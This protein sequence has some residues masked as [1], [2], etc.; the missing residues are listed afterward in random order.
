M[1]RG[2]GVAALLAW[3]L[4]AAGGAALTGGHEGPATGERPTWLAALE[5][6]P[7][8]AA[9]R[10]VP[11]QDSTSAT[12]QARSIPATPATV[13]FPEPARWD[14]TL[15]R[16]T[17][18]DRRPVRL[19]ARDTRAAAAQVRLAVLDRAAAK[20]VGASGFVFTADIE[21]PTPVTLTVDYSGFAE[22]YGASYADRLR[23]VALP[24]CALADPV[25]A[26]CAVAGTP[27]TTRN[28]RIAKT[29]TAEADLAG[30][31]VFAMVSAVGGED[32]TFAAS[33]M[34]ITGTWQ[35][36][37]GSG[38][39]GY[40]H[41]LDIPA[42]AG[43]SAPSLALGYSSGAIDGLTLGSN[44]QAGPAGL[45]WSDFANAFIE[46]RYEPCIHVVKTTDLCWL[47]DNA[48]ISLNGVSGPLVP[49][50]A[51]FTEWRVQSDPG[52]RVQ[53]LTGAPYTDIYQQ[54][55]WK[56]T[57]PDGT[58][59]FFGYGHMPGL[60]TNSI[61]SVP[62]IA[63]HSGEPCRSADDQVASCSQGWRWY[64]DRVVDP[65]GNVTSYV[66]ERQ[67]NWYAGVGGLF[68]HVG[69]TMYHR[70]GMLAHIFYGGRGWDSA[71][72]SGHVQF[73]LE[74]RCWFLV[75]ACPP[76]TKEHTGFPDVPTD[77]ICAQNQACTVYAPAF[78]NARRYAW[79]RTEV[80][81]GTAWKTV[82]Q[83]NL[84]HS[85]NDNPNGVAEKLQLEK[86]QYAAIAFGKLNAYPT[87]DF[88]YEFRDNRV[89][90]DGLIPRAMRHNRLVRITNQ[91]GG[92]T[93]VTYGLNRGCSGDYALTPPP[94]WDRNLRD[95]FPQSI[96][97][98]AHQLTGVFN[99]YLVTQVVESPGQGSPAITTTYTYEGD[100]AWAFDT[101]AFARDED[102]LGWSL[103]RGYGTVMIT[104]GTAAT[105]MR[106]FRGWDNDW[107]LMRDSRGDWVPVFGQ[108]RESVPT[109]V[110]S[111]I[112]Y[113]DH[114]SL[115]GRVLEEQQLGTLNGVA[116]SVLESRRNEY[117]RRPTASPPGFLSGAEWVGLSAT[118]ERL[119]STPTSFRERRGRTTYNTSAQ[120]QPTATLEEGWLDVSGDERCS[121]TTYADNPGAGMLVYPAVN[122]TVAGPCTSTQVLSLT[123]T[124]YDGSTV[125]GGP[126]SRGNPT[127]Q[128]I[129]VDSTR[130]SETTTEYD[131][132]GRPIKVTDPAGGITTTGY[133]V[134]SGAWTGQVPI[135]TTVT[136][137]LG[138]QTVTDLLPE[139][140]V[141]SKEIDAN[142]NVT[143]Y[144]YDEFG[145][146]TAVWL[147]TEPVA[148]AEPSWKF[149]YDIPNR[150]VR[151]QRLV[152]DARCCEGAVFEESW[153]IYDGFWRERQTQGLSPA[154]GKVL[155]T[156]TTYDN[157]GQV[158]DELVE[159]AFTGTPGRYLNGGS[160]WLN[161]TRNS[162]DELGRQVR[163]EW[164]R[165]SAVAHTTTAVYG[166]DVVT[167]TGPDGRQVRQRVDGLG[168]TV[169][170]E[171][172]DG[173]AW[174]ASTYQYD[175]ADRLLSVTDPAG[176]RINYTSNL[177]G[178]RTGQ[179]D[180]NRGSA[181]YT[182]DTAGRQIS[183][184][185]AR[186]NQ[187]H[188][189]YDLL[190]RPLERRAGSAT[191]TLLASWVYDAAPGGKGKPHRETTHT[192]GGNW[193]SEVLGYDSK[194]RPTG[195]RL[196]VPAGIAGLSG[197]YQVTQTYDRADR[198]RT[199]TY[200]AIGGLPAE[201]VTVGHNNLG[202]P[203]SLAGTDEYVWNAVYDDR[204]RRVSA[205]LG[206]RPGGATWMAK[207]W[208]YDVDQRGNSAE[209]FVAGPG[210]VSRQDL[211]FD[212]AGN[213]QESLKRLNGLS[214]R[215]CF[216]YDP[217]SRLTAAHTVTAGASCAAGTPGT[218][219]RPYAHG[220]EYSPD[221]KLT[222]RTENGIRTAYTYPAA[223]SA[224][225]HAPTRV[226]TDTYTWDAA[227]ALA[228]RTVAGRTETF[229][230]DQQGLLASVSGPV[231]TTSFVYDPAGQRL[232]RRTPDGRNTLYVAGHEITA[233]ASGTVTSAV[234]P[235]TFDGQLIAIRT[236]G[237]VD[238]LVSD[239][240]GSVELAIPAGGTTPTATRTYE[241]YG[242]V[243]SQD[244]DTT[245]DRGFVGQTEDA[246][247]GLSY[248]NA[249]YYDT[250]IGVFIS[251]DPIYDTGKP[252]T[253]NPYSYSV[254]NPTTYTD[255]GGA[256]SSYTF[257]LE[258]EN[259]QLRDQN[260]QLI[261]HIKTLNSHIEEL[262]DIIRKQQ[263]DIKKLLTY[264]RALEAEIERQASI[265]RQLQ[266]RIAYLQRV[267]WA[268]QRE[269]SRLRYIVARQQQII[270]YQA[271]VIR[272]QAG[273]IRYQAGVIHA[274][275]AT[276]GTLVARIAIGA[277]G[278]VAAGIFGGVG[279]AAGQVG[280]GAGG[281][282]GGS[283]GGGSG[284]PSGL[285]GWWTNN[286]SWI[287]K[288]AEGV[289]AGLA[290][291]S[292]ISWG[293]TL[294][295]NPF[296]PALGAGFGE[297]ADFVTNVEGGISTVDTC[298][299][300][301]WSSSACADSAGQTAFGLA[302]NL[303][304]VGW[305]A[306]TLVDG[307]TGGNSLL[308][309][310][311]DT[312]GGLL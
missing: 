302:T 56:V 170:V 125:L 166:L 117:E 27:L 226:G 20:R 113:V 255:P 29:L 2:G 274:Q 140:G 95:C 6:E 291:A 246:S 111:S 21:R 181:T 207:T 139:F 49:A 272:K 46:R 122:K 271:G 153:V 128:R 73:G 282:G 175:L 294:F 189:R 205:G 244:G 86:I 39:F 14:V 1:A 18:A 105:R 228:S 155:V 229:S 177:V 92:V 269:I 306:G 307:M 67:E 93:T 223:G 248:L 284:G 191:G 176:N 60:R 193:V 290:G 57:G 208:T 124:Y 198:T 264:I 180:P 188:T 299:S 15:D 137:P 62:V 278:R 146:L 202:L 301:G 222:A 237:G 250:T 220:Y 9:I 119:F 214:W 304:V 160:A 116:G 296:G 83:Y 82:A 65:D 236:L 70:A 53:R 143:E 87:T 157:R 114:P 38:E 260:K 135:R 54:Q 289:E 97:D 102:E 94:H 216:G 103:W 10:A 110:D 78:F 154:S 76:A 199:I 219:D 17:G 231:G 286:K 35:V 190:G 253:L 184:T 31:G 275:R 311:G 152:S 51:A 72:Y 69:N 141:P 239:A 136:N 106:L 200:P 74:W 127:R 100:P 104:K 32:G 179:Q 48:T 268:Q 265:I 13:A 118:T 85:F 201:T 47:S 37:P 101:G 273:I 156:E 130:W 173:Q 249:R 297:A 26:D 134:T 213:L 144:W 245:T 233:D 63:D 41:P 107:V 309:D 240:A 235:Y 91:F 234:R 68:G 145:R 178:W 59:Y 310:L 165:G 11:W 90:H 52:W 266:A 218:G 281:G 28:D 25:P 109:L 131:E 121:I 12:V 169:T 147:P 123:E 280:R 293:S 126:P 61:L 212:P 43:G 210:V 42:P 99:K 120:P 174:V 77:L 305:P 112:S 251:A 30:A 66:Y 167:V 36:S 276:I 261:G 164:F 300:E 89:D 279:K 4:V 287:F 5:R 151:S 45:G 171:E 285:S 129:M 149:S 232:L 298:F 217:R 84:I 270:R 227:G 230:W 3:V 158:R 24:G 308:N 295:G 64:L 34:S 71:Q 163:T 96:T 242:Q 23:L 58:Q 194:G 115:A 80:K 44:T 148:F 277:A 108:R 197:S 254:N 142:G 203:T 257:G 292:I 132:L 159:Q 211:V 81:V 252:K 162:Y 238:Y 195:S 283:W 168:R 186:G 182:Y 7:G 40:S 192:A 258:R 262:Q 312:L 243:R 215:E 206:P 98:G 303:G 138:H 224:R 172:S 55:Y 263:S 288:S 267:V 50:N 133:A 8:A 259:A 247:T 150:A 19:A 185:D 225:P 22:A 161:R 204:G 75:D 241:P 209:T 33:Q 88:A 16:T 187:I 196:T 221:G 79:V 256:Y 183:A